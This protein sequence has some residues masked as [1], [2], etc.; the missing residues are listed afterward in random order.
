MYNFDEK[1]EWRGIDSV[2]WDSVKEGVI[3]LWVADMDFPAFPGIKEALVKRASAPFYGYRSRNDEKSSYYQ[4]IRSWYKTRHDLDVDPQSVLYGPGTVLSLGMIVREFSAPHDGVLILSPVYTP[5]FDVINGNKRNVVEVS[6]EPDGHGRFILDISKIEAAL[7][8]AGSAV[9]LA[10]FCSPH[11]PGGRVWRQEEIAALLELARRRNI[12]A[13]FDELH[14]DFVYRENSAG[15]EQVF[16]SSAS[17]NEYSDRVIVV[18]GANK[19]F[20]LGGLHV[21]H[22]VINDQ[23]LRETIKTALFRETHHEGDVFAEKA[24]E[25]AY[26]YGAQWF[27]ECLAYIY[28]SINIAVKYLNNEVPGVHAFIPDGTYLIW[29]D[30]R[31]AIKQSNCKNVAEFAARLE[32]Q[33]AVK[34][35]AGSIFG[36]GGEG[37]IRINTACPRA[38]LMEGLKR[39]KG[40]VAKG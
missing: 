39:L 9:P 3:P 21:S 31:E 28:D 36:R 40:W 23:T 25:T 16:V 1:I 19:S 30:V 12:I 26:R 24:V 15:I 13:A 10:L 37:Y 22:F 35:T 14:Q 27:D 18:A 34:I 29:A 2:K 8:K 6:L 4:A 17:F 7:D 38:Q 11:N 33:A 32:D 5:F 20:S